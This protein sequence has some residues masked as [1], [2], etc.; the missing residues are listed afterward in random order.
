MNVQILQMI[1]HLNI[2]RISIHIP[3]QNVIEVG[4]SLNQEYSINMHPWIRKLSTFSTRPSRSNSHIN[5]YYDILEP[6]FSFKSR[7]CTNFSK[8]I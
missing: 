7:S 2:L 6:L 4:Q 3:N 1:T 5:G 8:S